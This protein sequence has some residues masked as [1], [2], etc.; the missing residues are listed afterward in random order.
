MTIEEKDIEIRNARA[1]QALFDSLPTAAKERVEV[2]AAVRDI[3]EREF[4]RKGKSR[5]LRSTAFEAT[6]VSSE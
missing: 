4:A 1:L 2:M 3:F 6:D 5:R